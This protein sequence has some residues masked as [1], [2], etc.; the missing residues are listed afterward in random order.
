MTKEITKAFII[1]QLEDKFGLR[2]LEPE[3]FGF[4]EKVIPVYDI[5][6]HLKTWEV[7]CF[8][9]SITGTG[10]YLFFTVP[11]TERWLLRAYQLVFY[12]VGAYKMSGVYISHRPTVAAEYVYLDLKANQTASYLVNL[13]VPVVLEPGNRLGVNV[14]TY[15]STANLELILDAQVE[16][17]R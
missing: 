3:V 10:G 14:D 7:K 15:V 13:P 2:D 16:T 12:A 6:Q 8:T 4:S 17:I 1:Q 11:K 5:E 9:T